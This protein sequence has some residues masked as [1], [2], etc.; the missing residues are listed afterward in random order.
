MNNSSTIDQYKVVKIIGQGAYGK[1]YKAVHI[2]TNTTVA[3]KSIKLQ[4]E[5]QLL[6][7]QL[8]ML[9]REMQILFKLS[10]QENN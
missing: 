4:E 3:L 7:L 8:V 6:H 2:P 10:R 9:A 1:V 5:P